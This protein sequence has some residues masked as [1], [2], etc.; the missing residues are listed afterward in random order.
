MLITKDLDVGSIL[1]NF[2]KYFIL[3]EFVI[4]I[5]NNN[6]ININN[7]ILDIKN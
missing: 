3:Y 1:Y 5:R 2:D 4:E 7:K 6:I